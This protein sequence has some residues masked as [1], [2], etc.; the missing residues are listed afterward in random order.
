MQ[1]EV[2]PRLHSAIP[3]VVN[4]VGCEDAR[5]L[6]QDATAMAAKILH[7]A[8]VR[9]KRVAGSSAAYYS[10]QHCRSG[11]RSVGSSCSDVLGSGTQLKGRTRITSLDEAAAIDEENG[12]EIFE[13]HDVLSTD[14]EDPAMTAA[15]KMDWESFWSGLSEREKAV[16][17]CVAEGKSL[18]DAARVLG[19]SDSTM[20]STKRDLGMKILE[21][22]GADILAQVQRLPGWKKDLEATRERLA[23]RSERRH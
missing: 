12:G 22:M 5:E 6:I 14:A 18:R 11:R 17:V 10:I 9:G 23:C 15:R 20:Q 16:V 1:E 4:F 8:E 19:V 21:F 7:N 3:Q 2:L 13:F